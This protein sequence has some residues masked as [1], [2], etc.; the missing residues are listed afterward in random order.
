MN[1]DRPIIH[2]IIKS[3]DV[4]NDLYAAS[5][6]IIHKY[7]DDVYKYAKEYEYMLK[8]CK[9]ALTK[10]GSSAWLL[11][12]AAFAKDSMKVWDSVAFKL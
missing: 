1:L 5:L 2:P 11:N 9:E 8:S 6:Q 3:G 10:H 7:K 4:Y 12:E